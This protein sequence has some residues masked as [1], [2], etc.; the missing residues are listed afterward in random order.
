MSVMGTSE[1]ETAGL[2][3]GDGKETLRAGEN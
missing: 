2:L 3:S 1:I